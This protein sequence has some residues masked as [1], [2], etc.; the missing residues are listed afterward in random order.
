M[1]S[2]RL[3]F[4]DGDFLIVFEPVMQR[5][6]ELT[7]YH[8]EFLKRIQQVNGYWLVNGDPV[9]FQHYRIYYEKIAARCNPVFDPSLLTPTS[10]HKFFVATD[11]VK[12]PEAKDSLVPGVSGLEQLLGYTYHVQKPTKPRITS[13]DNEIDILAL[14]ALL[15]TSPHL[16]WLAQNY[17]VSDLSKL[18]KQVSD[19]SREEEVLKELEDE[20]LQER[21]DQELAGSVEE[22]LKAMGIAVPDGFTGGGQDG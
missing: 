11:P 12:H 19:K 15:P 5:A 4:L 14:L 6:R 17:S 2:Y 9:F 16:P 18:V 10:R 8:Q 22:Q 7:A 1:N 13:G 21:F 3:D 20:W